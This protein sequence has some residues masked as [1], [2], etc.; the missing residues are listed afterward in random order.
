MGNRASPLMLTSSPFLRSLL[1]CFAQGKINKRS[2]QKTFIAFS[3]KCKNIVCYMIFMSGRGL[4]LP[5]LGLLEVNIVYKRRC[6]EGTEGLCSATKRTSRVVRLP[7][8]VP[9]KSG[10]LP[11]SQQKHTQLARKACRASP[12]FFHS[13]GT[14]PSLA[15]HYSCLFESFWQFTVIYY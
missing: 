15:K 4:F 2:E 6:K 9:G 12:S 14:S 10:K 8:V 13:N 1:I 7:E 5:S 3:V 11:H